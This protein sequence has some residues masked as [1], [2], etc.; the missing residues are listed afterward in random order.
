MRVRYKVG[1]KLKTEDILKLMLSITIMVDFFNGYF[2]GMHIGEFF[3]GILLILCS[4]IIVKSN[5]KFVIRFILVILFLAINILF[6]LLFYNNTNEALRTDLS[7]GLKTI[8]FF[9]LSTAII[10]LNKKNKFDKN[11][12]NH[13]IR[14]NILYTPVLFAVSS[15]MG[16]SN[17]GYIWGD[18]SIGF[19]GAFLSLNSINS[20]ML[21]MYIYCV[22]HFFS[23]KGRIWGLGAGYI[24]IPMLALGTK[25]SLAMIVLV[26]ALIFIVQ[27]KN[28]KTISKWMAIVIIV[29]VVFP[30]IWP[31]V[32]DKMDG[33]FARQAYLMKHRSLLSYIT[34][35]RSDR[36]AIVWDYYLKHF[37]FWDIFPGKG[38]YYSHHIVSEL[39]GYSQDVIPIEMDWMDILTAYGI[40]GFFYTYVYALY[41]LIVSRHVKKDEDSK[42]Y[43]LIVIIMIM[44]GSF[45]GHVFTE[46]ISS[47]FLS[48]AF[49]GYI[50]SL[51]ENVIKKYGVE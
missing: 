8:I 41:P 45:A 4:A 44:Y 3:R 23:R 49:C 50:I 16:R 47:T 48:L 20:A 33:V 38:Y 11:T 13:I 51:K 24:A 15:L 34:S 7:M 32:Y 46:A 25:T 42:M 43:L 9:A 35:T 39:M 21:L 28:E 10:T 27:K 12:I 1:I 40:C 5:R 31:I 29:A 6:S 22:Y 30:F 2:R 36:V 19:K 17:A 18:E 37:N 26:P 14:N